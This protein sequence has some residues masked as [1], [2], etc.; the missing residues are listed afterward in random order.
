VG[1]KPLDRRSGI[2][3]R[4]RYL[5]QARPP[6]HQDRELIPWRACSCRSGLVDRYH[7]S[8][9]ACDWRDRSRGRGCVNRVPSPSN[10]T[11]ATCRFD[12]RTSSPPGCSCPDDDVGGRKLVKGPLLRR[13]ISSFEIRTWRL[14]RVGGVVS[15]R[16]R[17]HVG[18]KHRAEVHTK[19]C[20]G[21]PG[22]LRDGG[23]S[24]KVRPALLCVDHVEASPWRGAGPRRRRDRRRRLSPGGTGFFARSE[25]VSSWPKASNGHQRLR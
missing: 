1:V 15:L 7:S 25:R 21:S 9:G 18:S 5:A 2:S 13:P 10:G 12:Q 6:R 19:R 8:K 3:H 16:G 17:A 24:S 11:E 22:S 23:L 4:R 14:D 20:F